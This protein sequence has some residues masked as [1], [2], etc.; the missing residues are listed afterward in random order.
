MRARTLVPALAVCL[1]FAG[2]G[3]TE[4]PPG[5]VRVPKVVGLDLQAATESVREAGLCWQVDFATKGGQGVVLQKPAPSSR[6]KPRSPV[7][8]YLGLDFTEDGTSE[9]L[10]QA[11]GCPSITIAIVG[12]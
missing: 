1:A 11:P 6:V 10:A 9:N 4:A 8:L 5:A 2:C 7:R 12:S 3:G